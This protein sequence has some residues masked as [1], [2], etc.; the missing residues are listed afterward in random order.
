MNNYI[1]KNPTNNY[2]PNNNYIPIS[3]YILNNNY[4]HDNQNN[5]RQRHLW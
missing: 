4:I 3:N 1:H 5:S 2:I